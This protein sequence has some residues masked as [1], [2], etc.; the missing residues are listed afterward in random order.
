MLAFCVL[1]FFVRLTSAFVYLPQ[2]ILTLI[3]LTYDDLCKFQYQ[4]EHGTL[5]CNVHLSSE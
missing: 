5:S 2:L 4:Q 1:K 3:Q